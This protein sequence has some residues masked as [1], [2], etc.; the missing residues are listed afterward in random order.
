VAVGITCPAVGERIAGVTGAG[1]E[2][3][4]STS[5]E[6]GLLF[7]A[8]S[9]ATATTAYCPSPSA[10]AGVKLQL[11]VSPAT[12]IPA[13]EPFNETVTVLLAS[14]VPEMVGN[15]VRNVV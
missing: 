3:W 5:L 6:S 13:T 12:A 9:R 8:A 7:P 14:A 10:A 1:T 15:L 11:P 4:N 2:T